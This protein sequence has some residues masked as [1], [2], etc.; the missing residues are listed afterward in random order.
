MTASLTRMSV[1][2]SNA[3]VI[4]PPARSQSNLCAKGAGGR[5]GKRGTSGGGKNH[6]C[7]GENFDRVSRFHALVARICG[8]GSVPVAL[9]RGM[10]V[11]RARRRP[12]V[13]GLLLRR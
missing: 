12:Y 13:R 11:A 5:S 10:R 8:G 4:A 2:V 9:A 6:R 1:L 7:A 3:V